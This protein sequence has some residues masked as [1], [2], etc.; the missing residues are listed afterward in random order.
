MEFLALGD[1]EILIIMAFVGPYDLL[2]MRGV[3]SRLRGLALHPLA[4]RNKNLLSHALEDPLDL[5]SVILHLAPCANMIDFSNALK[6]YEVLAVTTSCAVRKLYVVVHDSWDANTAAMIINNQ[7]RLGRVQHISVRVMYPIVDTSQLIPV[8][9]AAAEK[10]ESIKVDMLTRSLTKLMPITCPSSALPKPP[11]A[12]K[13]KHLIF[14]GW[15]GANP[16]VDFILS[17]HAS[18]LK[19]VVLVFK[20]WSMPENIR[21]TECDELEL[22]EME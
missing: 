16:H 12:P 6:T 20:N 3:C 8:I 19:K 9:D 22:A 15:E 14:Q 10:V 5:R 1:D 17:E 11:R 21:L 2:R 13:L 4:W 7:L 18:T